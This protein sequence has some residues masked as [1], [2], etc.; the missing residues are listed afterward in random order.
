MIQTI[1][2]IPASFKCANHIIT[3]VI[4]D[5]NSK[6]NYGYFC[7]AT[8]QINLARKVNVEE[9][10]DIKLTDQQVVN[11]FFH[12]LMHCFQFYYGN[13]YSET[14]AQVFA[15]FMYEFCITYENNSN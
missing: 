14:E 2:D 12:E 8:N 9:I 7:D 3:V 1:K 6:N 5:K 13:E 15:N 4:E 10:G 11:T